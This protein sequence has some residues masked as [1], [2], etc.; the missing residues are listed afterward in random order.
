VIFESTKGSLTNTVGLTFGF[1]QVWTLYEHSALG[2]TPSGGW[3]FGPFTPTLA[4]VGNDP[5]V[6]D[7]ETDYNAGTDEGYAT[8][9]H[10]GLLAAVRAR[11]PR[12]I[13]GI[14]DSPYVGSPFERPNISELDHIR[15]VW[16]RTTSPVSG[17]APGV[18]A[19]RSPN[20]DL[21]VVSHFVTDDAEPRATTLASAN[22]NAVALT[23]ARSH[24]WSMA[25][26]CAR[27]KDRCVG[28]DL[29]FLTTT[30]LDRSWLPFLA[31]SLDI[32][33]WTYFPNFA[34]AK[35]AVEAWTASVL[36]PWLTARG[37]GHLVP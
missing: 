18:T 5:V 12:S 26:V 22:S 28:N 9:V 1:P 8:L 4:D 17:A 19:V 35:P 7:V 13:I 32:C 37:F 23:V 24:T 6:I 21:S 27:T 25:Y 11:Y 31:A 10:S 30:Q 34:T 33:I 2:V 15:Q 16:G 20:I 3:S 29:T 36:Y 14:Y